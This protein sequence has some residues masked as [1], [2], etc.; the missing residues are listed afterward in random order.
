MNYITI[1][2]QFSNWGLFSTHDVLK[3][4]PRFD[5]RRLVEWQQKGYIQRVANRWYLFADTLR[6]ERL[7]WWIANRIYQPS[8]LSVETAL[9]HYG[10][11]PEGVYTLTSVS[12]RKTQ[13]IQ[14]P[15]ASFRYQHIKSALYFGYQILRVPVVNPSADRPVLIAHLEKA[16]LDFCY[17]NPRLTTVDDFA[18]LRLNATLLRDQLDSQRLADYLHL[19][20][21]KRLEQRIRVLHNYIDQY[22]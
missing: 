19:F 12:S 22:A 21:N 20:Q 3:R 11:I 13:L 8:Y 15:L 7:L 1:Q 10:M 17:L 6:D 5:T 9:S 4:N 2:Q 18:G 14:T 16:L